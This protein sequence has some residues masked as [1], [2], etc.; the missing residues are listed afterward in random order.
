MSKPRFIHP[1]RTGIPRPASANHLRPGMNFRSPLRLQLWKVFDRPRVVPEEVHSA[2]AVILVDVEIHFTD[3]IVNSDIVGEPIRDI[4]ALSIVDREAR[5]I[6]RHHATRE[7]AT[8]DIQAGRAG[9]EPSGQEI[10][11]HVLDAIGAVA[12][13]NG[14]A[15]TGRGRGGGHEGTSDAAE[16]VSYAIDLPFVSPKEKYLVFD[17]RAADAPAVLL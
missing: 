8:G 6:T 1:A 2:D 3:R 15:I 17:D 10:R 4:D 16:R 13:S 11:D 14:Q 12:G 5:S 9:R 7:R